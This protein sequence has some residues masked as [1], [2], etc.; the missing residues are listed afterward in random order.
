[1]S[2]TRILRQSGAN[3][4]VQFYVGGQLTDP[5]GNTA[6]LHTTKADG[7]DL[8]PLAT[9]TTRV[10]QGLYRKVMTPADTAEVNNLTNVWAATFSGAA[11]QVTT[12]AEIVGD[13]LFTLQQA[14]TFNPRSQAVIPL[15]S[16]TTYPDDTILEARSRISDDFELI[17][18]DSFFPRYRRDVLDG[19][20][21]IPYVAALQRPDPRAANIAFATAINL[22]KH[23]VQRL[24]SVTVNGVAYSSTDLAGI[25]VFESGQ[26][27][28]TSL[29]PWEAGIRN[30]TV[31]YVYGHS[32]CPSAITRAGLLLLV[33]QLAG[34]DISP[35]AL[36]ISDE[37]GTMTLATAGLRGA[38]YGLPEVDSVLDRYRGDRI[39]GIA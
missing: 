31:E 21:I 23:R 37:T 26:L 1:V 5:D 24:I 19:S 29:A 12:Y 8:Y 30:V 2:E 18:G 17:C 38:W 11:D 6:T 9:A 33:S 20:R 28:K 25:T 32:R 15:A 36:T 34:T 13:H 4:D 35:R 27:V 22:H 39:P 7:T 16:S 14:R 10:S 3:L